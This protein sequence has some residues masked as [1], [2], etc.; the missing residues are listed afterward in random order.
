MT[1]MGSTGAG[2]GAAG[3][4][5]RA[6]EAA[7]PEKAREAQRDTIR[8]REDR[9]RENWIGIGF[10]GGIRR[11][12]SVQAPWGNRNTGFMAR[13]SV[14]VRMLASLY[15]RLLRSRLG[16]RRFVWP[17]LAAHVLLPTE[18]KIGSILKLWRV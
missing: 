9:E 1:L 10:P 17:W 16:L 12:V 4:C 2:A 7:G 6:G 13:E 18:R 5:A 11:G 8:E 14:F 3:C 15:A